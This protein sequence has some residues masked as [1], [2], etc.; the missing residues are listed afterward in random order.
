MYPN[1]SID[2]YGRNGLFVINETYNEA[3]QK[4][5]DPARVVLVFSASLEITLFS[6]R[7]SYSIR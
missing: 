2:F 7:I 1:L 4:F 5:Y 3:D 6:C